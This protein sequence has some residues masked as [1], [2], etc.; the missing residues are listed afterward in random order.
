V[1]FAPAAAITVSMLLACC[2]NLSGS[3]WLKQQI[4]IKDHS[5]WDVTQPGFVEADTVAHCGNTLKGNFAWSLTVT[6]IKAT[7]TEIRAIWNKGAYEVT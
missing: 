5:F 7:W 2:E 3:L 4:P 1:S 6:D